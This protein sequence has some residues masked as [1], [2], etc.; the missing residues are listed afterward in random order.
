VRAASAH[1]GAVHFAR[2]L[3]GAEGRCYSLPCRGVNADCRFNCGSLW[4]APGQCLNRGI[5]L[6]FWTEAL[7][8]SERELGAAIK[9]S[10][11]NPA[12]KKMMRVKLKRP[13]ALAG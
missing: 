13:Q 3:E 7:P 6:T 9:H 1:F 12:P 10:A 4:F 11:L 5:D 2:R 8:E